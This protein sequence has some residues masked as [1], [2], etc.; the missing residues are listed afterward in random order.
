MIN[1]TTRMFIDV[2]SF[3]C[4]LGSVPQLQ[5]CVCVCEAGEGFW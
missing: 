1:L 4:D 2:W 5:V 3:L